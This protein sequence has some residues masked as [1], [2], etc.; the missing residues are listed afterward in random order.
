MKCHKSKFP[1]AEEFAL[2]A[3]DD[4]IV[5]PVE[6]QDKVGEFQICLFLGCL[7]GMREGNPLLLE[8][9][10]KFSQQ[11]DMAP[12][13]SLFATWIALLSSVDSSAFA[14]AKEPFLDQVLLFEQSDPILLHGL[15]FLVSGGSHGE[16]RKPL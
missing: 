15:A 11:A 10:V 4:D 14:A 16:E 7:N 5:V 2:V 3:D 8:A 9:I 1:M 13:S 6:F 12:R